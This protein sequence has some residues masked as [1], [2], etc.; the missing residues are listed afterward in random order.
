MNGDEIFSGA[1]FLD[2]HSDV[3]RLLQHLPS[4]LF[5]DVGA[6]MGEITKTILSHSPGSSVIAFEPFPGNW[7]YFEDLIGSDPRVVLHRMAVS[8]VDGEVSFFVPAVVSGVEPGWER[9]PGYSSLGYIENEA[10]EK[11]PKKGSSRVTVTATRLDSVVKKPVGFMKVDVQG[12]EYEVLQGSEALI[13]DYGVDIFFIEYG[14]QSEILEF[15]AARGY[16]LFDTPYLVIPSNV[17]QVLGDWRAVKTLQLST[18]A[19]AFYAWP[20][21]IPRDIRGH[22]AQMRN[23][24][25]RLGHVF[26]DMLCVR[27]EFMPIFLTALSRSLESRDT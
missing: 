12:G 3:Y 8:A 1:L 24:S 2:D 15:L 7:P 26:T 11:P 19:R 16:V 9:F 10:L 22:A 18:G 23:E 17:D 4:G 21:S 20:N 6:A 14:G 13:K 27:R 25:R 5:I